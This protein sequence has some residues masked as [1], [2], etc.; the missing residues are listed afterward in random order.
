M[1]KII[2]LQSDRNPAWVVE[3]SFTIGS[4]DGVGLVIKESGIEPEHARIVL[5]DKRYVLKDLNS[6]EGTFVNGQRI[7]QKQLNNRDVI[8]IGDRKLEVIDPLVDQESL[9]KAQWSLVACSSWLSGQEF[10]LISKRG[11]NIVK[12]GRGNHCDVILP[13]THL[14]REH[15][16]LRFE[17]GQLFIR[18]LNSAN[19][20]YINDAKASSGK[21]VPGDK[22]RFDV[23]SFRVVG[24]STEAQKA[25]PETAGDNY[26]RATKIRA[27]AEAEVAPTPAAQIPDLDRPK[28]WKTRPTSPGNREEEPSSKS[29]YTWGSIFIAALLFVSAVGLS[30]Y[31]FL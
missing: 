20:T 1:L 19:G 3:K 31:Y 25:V 7:N 22:L 11:D 16:E 2:E 28:N 26:S 12:V 27:T 5:Q 24:P 29:L 21:L 17:G 13:G 8:G 10:K 15:A 9:A 14:S 6:S 4:A 23:Y 30:L 18:D